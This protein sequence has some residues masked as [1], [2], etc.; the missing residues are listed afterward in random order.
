MSARDFQAVEGEELFQVEADGIGGEAVF[1][2]FARDVDFKEDPGA[3]AVF[4]GDALELAGH[5]QRIDAVEKLEEGQGPRGFCSSCR[6]PMKCHCRREGRRAVLARASWTRLSPKRVCPASATARMASGAVRFGDRDE[7]DGGG[8]AAGALRGGSRM[9]ARTSA[10]AAAGSCIRECTRGLTEG[11]V[12]PYDAPR[13]ECKS[14]L[15]RSS[16]TSL[17]PPAFPAPPASIRSRRARSVNKSG[18]WNGGSMS[19]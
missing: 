15:S 16:A 19:A 8:G 14:R 1:G 5:V 17:R 9:L 12:F 18:R 7:F 6:W 2:G 4:L 13:S 10:R 3:Q 11:L